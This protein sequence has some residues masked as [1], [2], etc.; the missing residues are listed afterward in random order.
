MNLF[1]VINQSLKSIRQNGTQ[2]IITCCIIAFGIM[3]LVGI[4]TAIDGLKSYINKDFSSMGANTFKIRNKGLAIRIGKKKQQAIEF[5]NITYI[6]A[7]K[8]KELFGDLHPTNIQTAGSGGAIVKYKGV[9]T[10]PNVTVIGVDESYSE[11]E[12]YEFFQGRNFSN[13]EMVSGKNVCLLGH[14]V[15]RKLFGDSADGVDKNVVIDGRRYLVIGIFESKGSSMITNDNFALIPIQNS[16]RFYTSNNYVIGVKSQDSEQLEQVIQEAIGTMRLAR[17]L[18]P[19]DANNF[20]IMKSDSISEMLNEN[21]TYA[22]IGGF[23][24]GLITLFGAAVGL[25]NI[26]LVSVTERTREIGTLKALGAKSNDILSQFLIEAIVIGQI[27]GVLGIL[28]GIIIGNLV[29][30][31][32]GG[33]FI[34]PWMWMLLGTLFCLIVGLASGI[35]PAVKAARQDPIE[36]LRFE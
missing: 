29:S 13:L 36:A 31:I 10:N 26:M 34:I 33:A 21:L 22:T 28:L 18:R 5:K 30:L 16:R 23:V 24:I 25:M 2:T 6:E 9:E 32:I 7:L 19:S 35:Y 15:A 20:D 27:G 17:Q 12:G 1:E 3:S 8:F 11:V 14:D 4:L